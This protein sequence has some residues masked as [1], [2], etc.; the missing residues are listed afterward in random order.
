LSQ[1]FWPFFHINFPSCQACV[2]PSENNIYSPYLHPRV[3]SSSL[4]QSMSRPIPPSSAI[5]IDWCSILPSIRGKSNNQFWYWIECQ[6]IQTWKYLLHSLENAK[7]YF[8][9]SAPTRPK[10]LN[11]MSLVNKLLTVLSIYF[12]L[13]LVWQNLGLSYY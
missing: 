7:D 5:I 9:S 12:L 3:F 11:Q 1:N 8:P 6:T 4:G 13:L 2:R 10:A